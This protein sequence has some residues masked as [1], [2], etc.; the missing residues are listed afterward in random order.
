MSELLEGQTLREELRGGAL[1]T[2]RAVGYAIQIAQ[3]LAAAH[4]KG[5]IHRDL[6]PENIFVTRTGQVKILDFGLA[7]LWQ[8]ELLGQ[9]ASTSPHTRTGLIL[10]T[11]GYM[12]PEQLR[13]QPV[14][15]RTDV[16]V[17]GTILYEMLTGERTFRGTSSADVI[18]AILSGDPLESPLNGRPAGALATTTGVL[19]SRCA[20]A[21]DISKRG[22]TRREANA[23]CRN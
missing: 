20:T 2:R 4:R 7:K 19:F 22:S 14:D 1:P 17:L 16:F 3:G 10:G 6:K 18:S 23:A 13:G 21:W 15:E 5:F 12:S 8:A 9:S 11:M